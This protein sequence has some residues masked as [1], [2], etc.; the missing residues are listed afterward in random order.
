MNAALADVTVVVPVGP[1]DRPA[2]QLLEQL[3]DLPR[4]AELHLVH[5][6]GDAAPALPAHWRGP[7]LRVLI[8]PAGRA[9]QQNA[10][11]AIATRPWL[12]FL[13]ADSRLGRNTLPALSEFLARGQAGFG[14]FRL[15]FLDD[16][17]ALVR[18]NA[19]GTRLRSDWLGLPFGDQ[20]FVL[21]R[22]GF[23]ALGGF[24]AGVPYGEDHAL[25]WRARRAGL[26]LSAIDAPLYTSARRYA[27]QGWWT[28]TAF[29]L[30][31]TA[32]QMRRFSRAEPAP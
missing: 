32:R 3:Q 29:H 12:W 28:T 19:L 24:D 26:P 18:L 11:A 2:P 4:G 16:G 5:A 9:M 25:V 30:R 31:E 15:R 13:H 1:G 8:A 23:D 7:Q 21:P 6:E 17:P 20:G 14:Y 27:E 22:A 10:G